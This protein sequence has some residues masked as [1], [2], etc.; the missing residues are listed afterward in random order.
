MNNTNFN[1]F[2]YSGLKLF[3]NNYSNIPTL[4]DPIFPKTG[5]VS[6]VG[7]SDTG[8]STLLRQL[9]LNIAFEDETFLGYKINSKTNKVIYVST[10]DD[11]N[12]ISISFKKQISNLQKDID[13]TKLDN[14][15]FIFEPD[16][17]FEKLEKH[18]S[19]IS[20]DLIIIDTF[21]DIF[22]GELNANIKVREFLKK[23]TYL[24]HQH[25][26]LILFLHHTGKGS[27]TKKASKNNVLGSQ[28]FEAKMRTV[29]EL[30]K[31]SRDESKRTLHILKGNYISSKLKSQVKIIDFNEE[32]LL[33]Y[34]EG[35]SVNASALNNSG[36]PEKDLIVPLIVDLKNEGV[37]LRKMSDALKKKG[38]E[39]GK[40]TIS[41]WLKE[42]EDETE[43][44]KG[45][46][47]D[48]SESNSDSNID[49]SS[50]EETSSFE[51]I[52]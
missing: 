11:P 38:F 32:T 10:E 41:N 31:H 18:L 20:V 23:Y 29:I 4:I 43:I 15:L 48:V 35:K 16:E 6:L 51:T 33:F 8:K 14:L 45:N 52:L 24:A 49:F 9:A 3:K 50:D 40:T 28:G 39:V 34:D 37:S 36:I 22:Q 47:I 46:E 2:P 12:S 13:E 27:E 17:I 1:G 26:C 19:D 7:S 21:T 42:Y 5:I 25:N 30:R 44:V